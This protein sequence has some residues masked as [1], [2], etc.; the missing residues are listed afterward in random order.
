MKALRIVLVI[1]CAL[2]MGAHCLRAELYL[3]VALSLASPALLAVRRPWAARLLQAA[4][5]LAAAEWVRTLVVIAARRRD[6]GEPW[7]RMALILGAVA[8]LNLLAAL[9]LRRRKAISP[10]PIPPSSAP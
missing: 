1:L 8:A 5:L 4:L 7:T 2:L 6:L 10:A 3:L 9:L